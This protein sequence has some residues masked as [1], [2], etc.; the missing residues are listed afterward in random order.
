MK[1]S[2]FQHTDCSTEQADELVKRYK[3]RGVRVERSLNQDYVTWTV[4]AFLPTSSTPAR[5][6]SRWRNRMWG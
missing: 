5:P 3:A 2:W 6:D 1:Y 4:S